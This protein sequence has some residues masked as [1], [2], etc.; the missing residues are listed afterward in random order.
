MPG[1]KGSGAGTAMLDEASRRARAS[2]ANR[3]HLLVLDSNVAAVG[4]YESRGRRLASRKNDRMGGSDM[5]ALVYA[6]ALEPT[7]LLCNA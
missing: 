3:L 6:L 4:F 2:G 5:V 1:H 7:L